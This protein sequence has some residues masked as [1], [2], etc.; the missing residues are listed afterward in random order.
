MP[1]LAVATAK[2]PVSERTG[3]PHHL[4]S[5]MDPTQPFNVQEFYALA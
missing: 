3:I 1:C 2:L 5:F 4:F